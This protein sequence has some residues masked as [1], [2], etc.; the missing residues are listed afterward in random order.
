MDVNLVGLV[1]GLVGLVLSVVMA[2]FYFIDRNPRF[3]KLRLKDLILGSKQLVKKIEEAS[4]NPDLIVAIHSFGIGFGTVVGEIIAVKKKIPLTVITVD[5]TEPEKT[6]TGAKIIG[7]DVN[8]IQ[9]KRV[10]LVDDIC[11]SGRTLFVAKKQLESLKCE[12]K[13]AVVLAPPETVTSMSKLDFFVSRST[14]QM[15]AKDELID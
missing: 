4:Y 2:Y 1:I 6:D 10:L 3:G 12:V 11:N 5:I 13:T 15:M 9:G 7:V 8:F 14:R